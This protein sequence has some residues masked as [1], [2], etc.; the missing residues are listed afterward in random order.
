MFPTR[1]SNI[2]EIL[3]MINDNDRFDRINGVLCISATNTIDD[4]I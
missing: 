2:D 4:V 3:R 1:N